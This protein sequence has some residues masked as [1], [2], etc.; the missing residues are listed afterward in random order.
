MCKGFQTQHTAQTGRWL[1][2]VA[3]IM[4]KSLNRWEGGRTKILEVGER[5]GGEEKGTKKD[6]QRTAAGQLRWLESRG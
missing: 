2:R 1:L 5:E 4:K 3:K 6:R